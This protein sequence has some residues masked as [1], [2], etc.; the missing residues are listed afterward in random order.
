MVIMIIAMKIFILKRTTCSTSSAPTV[1]SGFSIIHC[2]VIIANSYKQQSISY[3]VIA[4]DLMTILNN[5][6]TENGNENIY[7]ETYDKQDIL[8][9]HSLLLFLDYPL[10]RYYCKQLKTKEYIIIFYCKIFEDY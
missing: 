3:Y 1:Y 5:E 6:H 8:L 4:K 2:T 9:R 7:S 10:H